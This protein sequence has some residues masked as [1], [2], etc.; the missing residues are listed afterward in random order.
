MTPGW[1]QSQLQEAILSIASKSTSHLNLCLFIDALDEHDRN[2]KEL[3]STLIALTEVKESPM[4]KIRLCVAGRPENVFKDAFRHYPSFAIHNYTQTDIRLYAKDRIRQENN[5]ILTEEGKRG[6]Q[7]LITELVVKARG[8]FLCVRLVVDEI[9]EGLTDGKTLEEL[10]QLLSEIPEELED[11]YTRA[12]RRVRRGPASALARNKYEVYVVFQIALFAQEPFIL[13]NMLA[14]ARYLTVRRPVDGDLG[15]LSDE[16]MENR[17]NRISSGLLEAINT[18]RYR[19]RTATI[20]KVQFIHQTAKEFMVTENGGRLIR[21]TIGDKPVESGTILIFRYIVAQIGFIQG[22]SRCHD[23]H[24]FALDN[25]YNYAQAVELD[26]DICAATYIESSVESTQCP[27]KRNI[28]SR[29]LVH[30][31]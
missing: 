24:K 18:N 19:P 30:D 20:S 9:I 21:E 3:I 31:F 14:A 25:F 17:L 23:S 1:T 6:L 12:I 28:L 8:V 10:Q 26:E 15:S 5:S 2:H 11:L 22:G 16:Q 29:I 13:Y 7:L 27:D 4:F